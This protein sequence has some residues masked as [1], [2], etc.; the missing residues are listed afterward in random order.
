MM[1]RTV[2]TR[3]RE[4]QA[5]RQP[6]W[7]RY[8]NLGLAFLL[9]LGAL[10]SFGAAGVLFEGWMQLVGGL[11]GVVL[12]VGLWGMFAAPRAKRRLKGTNLLLFKIAIFAVAAIILV[13]IGQPGWGAA[14]IALAAINLTLARLL[15]Q[16]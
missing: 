12:F 7:L 1:R 2:R 11:V 5:M 6:Q 9:E 15:R 3:W 16:H 14:L 4:M 13:A 10:F 8:G